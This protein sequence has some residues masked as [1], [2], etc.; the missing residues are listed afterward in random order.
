MA[1]REVIAITLSS[2]TARELVANGV[3]EN[4][5][6]QIFKQLKQNEKL[7]AISVTEVYVTD[8]VVSSVGDTKVKPVVL[9]RTLSN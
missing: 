2:F 5:K 6:Y 8:L 9:P 1:A 3:I 4:V 7:T